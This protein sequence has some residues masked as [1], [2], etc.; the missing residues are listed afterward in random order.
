MPRWR[1]DLDDGPACK[2]A[3]RYNI[4]YYVLKRAQWQNSNNDFPF[5]G[6]TQDPKDEKSFVAALLVTVCRASSTSFFGRNARWNLNLGSRFA[7]SKIQEKK[8][9]KSRKLSAHGRPMIVIDYWPYTSRI[10]SATFVSKTFAT[11]I[12]K[13]RKIDRQSQNTSGMFQLR[14]SFILDRSNYISW[15]RLPRENAPTRS[16]TVTI[17]PALPTYD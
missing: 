14:S 1:M 7:E 8:K 2:S 17:C 5:F 9:S 12:A 10:S 4:N 15:N 6:P 11:A 13:I 16:E 3:R